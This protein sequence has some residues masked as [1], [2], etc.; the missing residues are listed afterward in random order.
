MWPSGGKKIKMGEIGGFLPSIVE[1]III[2]FISNLG[3]SVD[4]S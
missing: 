2:Q 4:L 3:Y 1:L